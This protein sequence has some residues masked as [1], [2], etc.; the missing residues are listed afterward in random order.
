MLTKENGFA[1]PL[2]RK[3]PDRDKYA[4]TFISLFIVLLSVYSNSFHGDWHFDDFAN[5]V[6]N[7][8]IQIQSL[9]FSEIKQSFTGIYQDRLLRP[10]SYLSFALNYYCGGM[11]VFGFHVVNFII[12]YLTAVFLFLFIHNTLKL[13]LIHEKYALIAYPVALLATFFWALN[14]VHVTSITY[15]VQRMSSMVGLFYIM[16]MYFY[17]KARTTEKTGSSICYFV[18]CAVAALVA[19][20]TKE[21]AAMLPVSI[22]LFDLFLIQGLTKNNIIKSVKILI[23]PLL[24]IAILGFVYTGG[25]SNILD[26]Y[27]GRNFTLAQ[28]LLTEPRVI[29]FYLSLLFYPI[30]SRLSFLYDI[31]VSHS[32]I[33]PWPTL[34]AVLLIFI[35]IGFPFYIARKRPL[36]SFCIIFFFINHLLEGSFIPLELIYEHRNYVPSMLLFVPVAE[37]VIFTIDYFSYK[38]MFQYIVAFSVIVIIFGLGDMTYRRNEIVSSEFLLWMDNIEKSPALSRPHTN[39]GLFYLERDQQEKGL[40]H[41]QKAIELNNFSN[42][43]VRDIQDQN[44]G[45]YYFHQGNYDLALHYLEKAAKNI[46]P[47]LTNRIFVARIKL[48]KNEYSQS[49]ALIEPLLKKHPDDPKL[50]EFLCLI[51]LKEN[52]IREADICAKSFLKNNISSTFPLK[53]LAEVEKRKGNIS[54]AILYWKLYR[55]S[56]PIDPY[57]NLAL[58]ELYSEANQER[59]LDEELAKLFCLKKTLPIT[60]Y[61]NE[62]SRDPNLLIYVPNVDKIRKIVKARSTINQ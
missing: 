31:E 5:I 32:L 21:N 48:L 8:H 2:H 15:I 58:I 19:V 57:V 37:F 56:F 14:P 20:L 4:F 6:L 53:I 26:G 16:S 24:L 52:K 41:F 60:A 18:A 47:D 29:L 43:Y 51:L 22:F 33:Q 35:I 25:F 38:K 61:I 59:E 12:H 49:Y 46:T 55:N 1:L 3:F 11:N 27:A 36:V 62:L 45:V 13:P 50:N 10:F 34:P 54:S 7:P 40:Y 42:A 23:L 17:L 30:G 44:L 39:M 9:S 28:R